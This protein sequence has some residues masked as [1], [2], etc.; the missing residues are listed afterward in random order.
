MR[1]VTLYTRDGCCLCDE[2]RK[3]LIQLRHRHCF[4]LTERDIEADEALLREYMERI[5]VVEIDGIEA[6]E[7]VIDEAELERALARVGQA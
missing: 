2:V 1:T 4:E 6:F 5:P 3:V 7:L